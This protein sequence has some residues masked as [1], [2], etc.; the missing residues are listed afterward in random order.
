MFNYDNYLIDLDGTA[1]LGDKVIDDCV[2]FTNRCI[3]S[4][5]QFIFVTNNASK[6]KK[7][8]LNKLLN[9][10][11]QLKENQI[12]TTIDIIVEYVNKNLKKEENIYVIGS[13]ILINKLKINGFNPYTKLNYK[14]DYNIYKNIKNV[15]IGYTDESSYS[16]LAIASLILKNDNSVFLATNKDNVI[17]NHLGELPG[18]GSIVKLIELVTK[19]ESISLGKPSKMIIEYVIQNFNLNP[20][21]TCIIGDNYDTDIMAGI[22]SN[23]DTIFVETGVTKLED[24]KNKTMQ[25]TISVKSL[26]EY[27]I[28][29]DN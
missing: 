26:K 23:I 6:S 21:K 19:K 12:V 22:N 16:D 11:Y 25:P 5:K 13:D 15:I 27:I 8:I 29:E 4:N 7:D 3:K 9:M 18:N 10:G 24:L 2:D 14:E 17:P 20:Q 1:Y 28:K